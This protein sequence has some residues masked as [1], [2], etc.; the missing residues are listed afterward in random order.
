LFI[1]WLFVLYNYADGCLEQLGEALSNFKVLSIQQELF[2]DV[3][4]FGMMNILINTYIIRHVFDE[5][6]TSHSMSSI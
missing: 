3:S 6:D 1:V 4:L 2:K 5:P